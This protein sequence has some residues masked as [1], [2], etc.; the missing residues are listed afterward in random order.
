MVLKQNEYGPPHPHLPQVARPKSAATALRN[1]SSTP[2]RN[3][4]FDALCREPTRRDQYFAKLATPRQKHYNDPLPPEIPRPRVLPGPPDLERLERLAQP[5]TIHRRVPTADEHPESFAA[6]GNKHEKIREM[7]PVVFARLT[8]PKTVQPPP[9]VFY[10]P[11]RA[12]KHKHKHARDIQKKKSGSGFDWNQSNDQDL[13]D[14]I[15]LDEFHPDD[16]ESRRSS[17]FNTQT[18]SRPPPNLTLVDEDPA[19][20]SETQYLQLQKNSAKSE[21]LLDMFKST[22]HTAI[23]HTE[24][25]GIFSIIDVL[26]ATTERAGYDSPDIEAKVSDSKSTQSHDGKQLPDITRLE[27]ES[28]VTAAPETNPDLPPAQAEF[29]IEPHSLIKSSEI[30]DNDRQWDLRASTAQPAFGTSTRASI[31]QGVRET[32][33][34]QHQ[35][36]FDR[37]NEQAFEEIDA[38][39]QYLME[40]NLDYSNV[41]ST[42]NEGKLESDLN[43]TQENGQRTLSEKRNESEANLLSKEDM[44]NTIQENYRISHSV[45]G[46]RQMD[47]YDLEKKNSSSN[48]ISQVLL[49]RS[50]SSQNKFQGAESNQTPHQ[51]PQTAV[52]NATLSENA[53]AVLQENG[54]LE[55]N[56]ASA[57]KRGSVSVE[58]SFSKSHDTVKGSETSIRGA[59]DSFRT[60]PNDINYQLNAQSSLLVE[61][62]DLGG[63]LGEATEGKQFD[64][65]ESSMLS[66][67]GAAISGNENEA[68]S[69]IAN[70]LGS[71]SQSEEHADDP[72]LHNEPNTFPVETQLSNAVLEE[73]P[74]TQCA[75]TGS[76]A[77]L[78]SSSIRNSMK[79]RRD[80]SE[81]NEFKGSD[82]DDFVN[83]NAGS[84]VGTLS[85]EVSAFEG[86]AN[87]EL[88]ADDN[89]GIS[90]DF[91]H[92]DVSSDG[93]NSQFGHSSDDAPFASAEEQGVDP[94]LA[95][96]KSENRSR[97]DSNTR[98]EGGP[99]DDE[100]KNAVSGPSAPDEENTELTL[101]EQ[102]DDAFASDLPL[103]INPD[104]PQISNEVHHSKSI[105]S[106]KP[107]SKSNLIESATELGSP[108]SSTEEQHA[109][110]SPGRKSEITGRET[111]PSGANSHQSVEQLAK[112]I[113]LSASQSVTSL[114]DIGAA[115][116]ESM[117]LYGSQSN[118]ELPKPTQTSMDKIPIEDTSETS[119]M[120]ASDGA[121]HSKKLQKSVSFSLEVLNN[122]AEQSSA[123]GGGG[124]SSNRHSV[125]SNSS[126][127]SRPQSAS[128]RASRQ[129]VNNPDHRA[130]AFDSDIPPH[131][132]DV[133]APRQP[134]LSET[135]QSS[136]RDVI[137]AGTKSVSG[138]SVSLPSKAAEASEDKMIPKTAS[139]KASREYIP[140]IATSRRSFSK[141]SIT[142]HDSHEI[143]SARSSIAKRSPRQ[144]ELQKSAQSLHSL[145]G[146]LRDVNSAKDLI[147]ASRG[148]LSSSKRTNSSNSRIAASAGINTNV[149]QKSVVSTASNH[150]ITDS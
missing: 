48:S 28:A 38:A 130:E 145:Q 62:E 50:T 92:K 46:S 143:S 2:S 124:G 127:S 142:K 14:G 68:D 33:P 73:T 85:Q 118:T 76:K 66:R 44:S 110:A 16:V 15:F 111:S 91:T 126:G 141:E 6:S 107:V 136:D 104:D 9:D 120:V 113:V 80:E 19:D 88:S 11:F 109:P 4:A 34:I 134:S 95:V 74:E 72:L 137:L 29:A 64:D 115:R 63:A 97:S 54:N 82:G 147:A 12:T 102:S 36:R 106:S 100:L 51:N 55:S 23:N 105:A 79:L 58:K 133:T 1:L 78:T 90:R 89:Q 52:S 87:E 10:V 65:V 61:T 42:E 114:Q 149:N 70:D 144:S 131:H 77:S 41:E 84:L 43:Q 122:D 21:V 132:Q 98:V 116:T 94:I 83:N 53:Q 40:E 31:S 8:R 146:S 99:V 25:T 60:D 108:G 26:F 128:K 112:P 37:I 123:R 5:R 27:S 17:S 125:A 119:Y 86:N 96:Q 30:V 148:E 103:K 57:S 24:L 129:G 56:T 22:S 45:H 39:A 69:T 35:S 139:H 67:M 117:R 75:P 140:S 47:Q 81:A 20:Q 135:R 71:S 7:D 101:V 93:R 13:R 150:S 49:S 18:V 59:A 32:Q 3:K 138:S 121:Q